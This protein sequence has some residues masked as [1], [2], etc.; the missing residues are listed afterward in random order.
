M[1][2]PLLRAANLLA[3]KVGLHVEPAARGRLSRS[4]QEVAGERGVDVPAL[5]AALPTDDSALQELLDVVTVQ[6]SA[7]F[8]DQ[9][10]FD[11]LAGHLLP[12]LDDPATVWSAGCANGQEAYSLA[13]VLAEA[14]RRDWQVIATDI[15]QQALTRATTGRYSGREL[16]GLPPARLRRHCKPV[17]D[18]W[19]VDPALRQ[20]VAVRRHNLARDPPPVA[21]DASTVVFCR[22]VLIYLRREQVIALLERLAEWLPAGGVLFLGYAESLC[23]LTDRFELQ[24]LG[25]AF[26]YRAA[27]AG[28]AVGARA[29]TRSAAPT[30]GPGATAP[31]ATPAAAPETT[32]PGGATSV[33]QHLAA[34]EAASAAGDL[35]AAIA[36]FG[37]AVLLDP[38]QPVAHLHRGLLLEARGDR[39]D[40]HR[41]Y[42]SARAALRR[43]S[44]G[45]VEAVL[46]GFAASE[47]EALLDAKLD[48]LGG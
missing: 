4:L 28:D 12:V 13:M 24:R 46:E 26:V 9:P 37:Q 19:E 36:A 15:S 2:D 39:R 40:A 29:P 31:A 38:D 7:F 41:A 25:D 14:G 22:N 10:Q 35:T 33:A 1:A 34:G 42:A 48:E 23:H 17:G 3:R 8:R 20:R 43:S 27:P 47:L 18:G 6:E 45:V 5:V 32:V 44:T 16:R 11:A 30:P 21:A